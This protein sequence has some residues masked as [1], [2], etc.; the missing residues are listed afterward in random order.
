[1]SGVKRETD[2]RALRRYSIAGVVW[3]VV[4]ALFAIGMSLRYEK[5]MV[6]L[7]P[8]SVVYPVMATIWIALFIPV[9]LSIGKPLI[10]RVR[11]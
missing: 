8:K 3:S 11:S 6:A 10:T 7:A 2:E 9:F 5:I 4:G 1:M